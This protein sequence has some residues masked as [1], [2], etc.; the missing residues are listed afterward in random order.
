VNAQKIDHIRFITQ[1]FRELQGLRS[2]V[3]LGLILLSLGATAFFP[4]WPLLLLQF[5]VTLGSTALIFRSGP[6]YRRSFGEVE[7]QRA[8]LCALSVY[9][10]AGPVPLAIER[11]PVKPLL[12]L[13]I[14]MALVAA[15][16]LI[17]RTIAPSATLMTDGSGVDPW[18]QLHTPVVAVSEAPWMPRSWLDL[19][20]VLGQGLYALFGVLFLGVWLL[21]GCRLS[22]SYYLALGALLLGLAALGACLGLVLPALWSLGG[23]W[24][25]NFALLALAHLWLALILCGASMLLTGLLDHWQIVRVLRPPVEEPS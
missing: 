3:P 15:L 19:K 10:P 25:A 18:V 8:E 1:H 7:R 23:S 5:A 11:Q 24:I 13:L 9:S 14:P 22:Q 21:R 2:S 12:R 17:L 16:F 4:R 6:Y 20:P